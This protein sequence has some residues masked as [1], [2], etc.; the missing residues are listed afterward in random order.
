MKNNLT[1]CPVKSTPQRYEEWLKKFAKELREM[2]WLT[3]TDL[4]VEGWNKAIEEIIGEKVL[5]A[6]TKSKP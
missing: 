6:P 2:Y 3:V 1:T 4:E 5:H